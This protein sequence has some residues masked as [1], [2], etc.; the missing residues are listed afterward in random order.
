[1][2]YVRRDEN[3][4]AQVLVRLA[5]NNNLDRV[6]RFD[7]PECIREIDPSCRAICFVPSTM[8]LM[9]SQFFSTTKKNKKHISHS[10]LLL[11]LYH[12]TTKK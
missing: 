3:K 6:W 12:T 9:N 11:L 1:M 8:I 2:G 10:K 7:P 4:V 5:L